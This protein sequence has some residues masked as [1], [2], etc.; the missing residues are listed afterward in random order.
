MKQQF[1]SKINGFSNLMSATIV[2]MTVI[3]IVTIVSMVPIVV[4]KSLHGREMTRFQAQQQGPHLF[5]PS[6]DESNTENMPNYKIDE[7]RFPNM[8]FYN[9]NHRENH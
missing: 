5:S 7:G 2:M 3:S 8:D 1:S 4:A 9:E 6:N